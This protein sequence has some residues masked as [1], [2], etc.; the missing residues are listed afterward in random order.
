[1]A[2]PLAD[3][4]KVTAN[5]NLFIGHNGADT[6]LIMNIRYGLQASE[7]NNRASSGV[8]L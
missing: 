2:R 7:Y 5:T 8:R 6:D 1:M 4:T 3:E